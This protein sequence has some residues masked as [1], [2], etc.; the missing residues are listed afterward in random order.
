MNAH[1]FV[2]IIIP[3]KNE[4]H[5]ITQCIHYLNRLNYPKDLYEIIVADGMSADRT[6]E[7]AEKLGAVVVKNEKGTVSPGRNIAFLAAKGD[8][9][10]FT[11]ADCVVDKD[12]L[13]NAIKYFNDDKVGCVGGP[14]FTP[15]DE[16]PF[17]KAVG[18]VFGEGI[19]AA[20]SIHARNLNEIKTVK[21]IP[22]CNA[23]YKREVLEKTMPVDESLLTCDDTELNQRI[24]DD[25]YDL[26]YTPDV[27]VWHYRRPSPR[28]LW[29][30]MYRYAIGR[31]QV[32]KRDRRMINIVHILVGIALP[33]GLS[34]L[35]FSPKLFLFLLSIYLVMILVYSIRGYLKIGSLKAALWI[36][37]V[38]SIILFS[39]STGFMRELLFPLKK[40]S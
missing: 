21:S 20:G 3:A 2:S 11:D 19:F 33:A 23:I 7:A 28:R 4:E 38:I 16:T 25:G 31:L 22:G 24:I 36:A 12:W 35:V 10:A 8:L 32:G 18:F 30:Q 27:Y 1:P 14:N 34:L 29:R 39:W 6:A 9:V 15:E 26:L 13:R 5:L 17:G 37:P 40:V